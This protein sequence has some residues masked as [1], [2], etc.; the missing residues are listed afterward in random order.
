M[1][2]FIGDFGYFG[3]DENEHK[4]IK[5]ISKIKENM[6]NN[7][8]SNNHIDNENMNN[9]KNILLLGGDNFYPYGIEHEKDIKLNLF[10][11]YF[12]FMK[13]NQIYGVLGNHDYGGCINYQLN[14]KFFNCEKNFYIINKGNIDIYMIDTTVIDYI[15]HTHL[16]KVYEN[17]FPEEHESFH[18]LHQYRIQH[19]YSYNSINEWTKFKKKMLYDLFN[20][21]NRVLH[22]LDAS[23]KKSYDNKKTI[24]LVGHYPLQSYGSYYINNGQNITFKHLVPLIL[25][26]NI[27]YYICGHDHN[28][29]H[30]H[31][32]YDDLENIQTIIQ[33]KLTMD[34]N[35]FINKTMNEYMKTKIERTN[36]TINNTNNLK[37]ELHTFI[38][39]SFVETYYGYYSNMLEIYRSLEKH[40]AVNFDSTRNAYLKITPSKKSI[41]ISFIDAKTN[42]DFYSVCCNI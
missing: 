39:G 40:H 33:F 31:Y 18:K 23:L 3:C 32:S 41:L 11:K 26:Y 10:G 4:L 21:R 2:Y 16:S 35:E 14:N 24:I 29:Q 17:I 15:T 13:K 9:G 27:N 37:K 1:I 38:C 7:T 42:K 6:K 20:N 30:L 19:D 12:N 28:N 36:N 22:E 5:H 25:K 8:N 34:D